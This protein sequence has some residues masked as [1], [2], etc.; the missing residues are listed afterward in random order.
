MADSVP[1]LQAADAGVHHEQ[2]TIGFTQGGAE[3]LHLVRDAGRTL[4]A[5]HGDHVPAMPPTAG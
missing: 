3:L 5:S 2:E 4:P 1:V